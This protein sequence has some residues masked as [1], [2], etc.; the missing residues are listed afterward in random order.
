ME[1]N[2]GTAD[3]H[4]KL[5]HSYVFDSLYIVGADFLSTTYSIEALGMQIH[6][7]VQNVV[8]RLV[9]QEEQR[10]AILTAYDGFTSFYLYLGNN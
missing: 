4:Q 3:I 8:E 7:I 6:H 5:L 1:S 2:I 9:S 10:K